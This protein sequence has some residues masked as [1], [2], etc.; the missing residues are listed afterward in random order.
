[1]IGRLIDIAVGLNGRQR[2]T[3]E[4]DGDFRASFESLKDSPK[5]D[6][7]IK[8]HREK[9]SANANAYFHLLI[10][11]I[12]EVKGLGIDEVKRLM[13]IEY[14]TLA[15]DADGCTVGFKL[16][17]SVDAATLYPYVKCFDTREEN[18]KLFN[19]YLVFKQTHEMDTKE[20]CR[21]I[22]GTILEAR[23][24]GIETDTPEQVEKFKSL[25]AQAEKGR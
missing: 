7:D 22:D 14:G 20:M 2:L 24:L 12:A 8:K 16:P 5:L 18:G 25:W 9:R 4:L 19:C 3:V 17:V 1:M 10:G 13:V 11:K 15:K 23:A 21:L 6:I